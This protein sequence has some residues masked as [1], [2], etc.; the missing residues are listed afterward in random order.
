[1]Y[2]LS[3][4]KRHAAQLQGIKCFSNLFLNPGNVSESFIFYNYFP[5]QSTSA[6]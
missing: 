6:V 4:Y 1:M 3:Q 2:T 5:K